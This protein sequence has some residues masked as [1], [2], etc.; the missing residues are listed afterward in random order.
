MPLKRDP[1]RFLLT[2]CFSLSLM[3]VA[4]AQQGPRVAVWDPVKPNREVRL[5]IAPEEMNRVAG[6]LREA[7]MQVERVTEA[8]ISDPA[9]FSA[10]RSDALVMTG[11]CV[12]RANIPAVQKFADEGGVLIGLYGNAPFTNAI[13]AATD[14]FWEMS[15]KEPRF[16]WQISDICGYY[17]VHYIYDE[18]RHHQGVK[19]TATPLLK[20]HVP[21]APDIHR[22]MP[23]YWIVP[24]KG[25]PGEFYPLVRS[26]RFDGTDVT[27][28]V[29]VAKTTVK[30]KG[31][32]AEVTRLGIFSISGVFTMGDDPK[33]W[34]VARETVVAMAR[35]AADLRSGATKLTPEDRI[36]LPEDLPSPEPL[37]ARGPTGEVNPD[38]AKPA[39][40]WG[41][42]DGASWELAT[43]QATDGKLPH[44]LGP[45]ASA[46]LTVASLPPG[47]LFLRV[48]GAFQLSGAG[49]AADWN[50]QTV[51][52]ELLNYVDLSGP[53]N[54]GSA[55]LGGT[56][57]EFHRTLFLPP[58]ESAKLTLS[59]P[60]RQPLYF[61][62]AQ[63]ETR[64]APGP[65]RVI[66]AHL[67]DFGDTSIISKDFSRQ[68]G[69]IRV[70]LRGQY[71]G[72]PDDPNRWAR[73]DALM[74]QYFS[75]ETPVQLILMGTPEW[76]AISAER[77][78]L[79]RAARRPHCVP[80]EPTKYAQLLADLIQRYGDRI[81]AYE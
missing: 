1:S 25:Q 43:G 74:K 53:G 66:G 30:P 58:A 32:K 14:G 19:H 80:P 7:G 65:K 34:P 78:A 63:V 44:R 57:A 18:A 54:F 39:A 46:Q 26:Q 40:R 22:R 60:G 33:L 29:W 31:A 11:D 70:D 72:P 49:L 71:I 20:K 52:N 59:N 64:P 81:A 68:W 51:W 79:G 17:S 38:D 15:P 9:A 73:T 4:W 12:P 27:P 16:A 55:D 61:D 37:R 3:G 62:A 47:P 75:H 21:N 77:Y 10:K 13:A 6:W 35:L 50:G 2:F 42:F 36:N 5:R 41:K 45:G 8:Q 67:T 24:W 28:Q 69:L 48:R 23:S 56:P 76:A